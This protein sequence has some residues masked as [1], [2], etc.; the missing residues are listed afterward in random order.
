MDQHTAIV[1]DLCPCCLRCGDSVCLSLL[2]SFLIPVFV[3]LQDLKAVLLGSS[4]K[5]FAVEW[6]NQG[7]AFSE[8]RDLRYG[9]MQKKVIFMMSIQ[10]SK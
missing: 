9:I 6:R 2:L 5:C 1:G 8:T 10:L 7:F 4:S 3:I